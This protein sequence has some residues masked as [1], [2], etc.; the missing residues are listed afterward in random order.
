MRRRWSKTRDAE[1]VRYFVGRSYIAAQYPEDLSKT[2][3]GTSVT[4]AQS[5]NFSQWLNGTVSTGVNVARSSAKLSM[6]MI[7]QSRLRRKNYQLF[8]IFSLG[9]RHPFQAGNPLLIFSGSSSPAAFL[10]RITPAVLCRN[11][12]RT[13]LL[14][15]PN[16]VETSRTSQSIVK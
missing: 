11:R 2:D 14:S 13:V 16:W 7:L 10:R 15:G 5:H 4:V 3:T 8:S 1:R 12:C 6:F 9:H